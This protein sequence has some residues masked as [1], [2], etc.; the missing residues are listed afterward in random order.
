MQDRI[1]KTVEL[2]APIERVWRALTNHEEF[3]EWFRVKLERP[4]EVGQVTRGQITYPGHEHARLEAT[5]KTMEAE[6]V[7]AFTWNPCGDD[8]EAK[9]WDGAETLVEFKLEPTADGTRLHISESGFSQL[10]EDV[11]ADAL[12][13]NS[14]GWDI[15][16][17]NISTYVAS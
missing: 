17:Q 12:R 16:S 8:P 2:N 15:Q 4:F 9:I 10:P 3:G 7:F 5:V 11:R 13:R 14:G 1:E 6:R